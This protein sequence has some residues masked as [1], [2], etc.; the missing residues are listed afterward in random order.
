MPPRLKTPAK[1]PALRISLIYLAFGIIWILFSDRI[2]ATL[3]DRDLII[4]IS[5][6]KGWFYVLITSTILYFLIRRNFDDIVSSRR[7]LSESEERHRTI[8]QTAMDGFWLMDTKGCILEANETLCR[9]LGYSASE[10]EAK[11]ITDLEANETAAD[12]NAHFQ[13]IMVRGEDRF[14][15]RLRRKDGSLVDV[16]VSAKHLPMEDGRIVAFIRDITERKRIEDALTHSEER[17]R[18]LFEMELDAVLMLDWETGRVLEANSSALRMYGYTPE[19]F[20]QLRNADLSAEPAVTEKSIRNE[21]TVVPLRWHRKKDGTVFPVEITG[22]YFDYHGSKVHVAAIRDIT[23]LHRARQEMLKTEKLESL[24]VL[25]GGIAHDFNNILSVILGNISLS[26]IQVHDPDKVAQ[27]LEDAENATVRAKDLTQQLLT[28]SRGGDPVK[29]VVNVGRLLR[30]AAGFAIHGSVVTCEFYLADDLWTVEADEGQLSQVIHNLVINAIQAMPKGGT[31]S[32]AA[33]NAESRS[34]GHKFVKISVADTGTGIPDDLLPKIFDPY[35]TTKQQG[36]GLGLAS[37]FSIIRKHDGKIRVESTLGKGTT[38]HIS[39]PAAE[40]ADTAD[41]AASPEVNRGKGRV[42]VMDDEEMV[43]E[44]TKSMLEECGYLVECAKNGSEAV[45][46][47]V[48]RLREGTPFAVV[49]MDLTIPGEV[50]GREAITSLL[51]IDPK[52]KAIVSSGYATD[53]V[54]AN[55]REYGFS[56]VLSKPYRVEEMSEVLQEVLKD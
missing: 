17:Y 38:F 36:S 21:E 42:L 18:K 44:I 2:V 5:I 54:M 25:A 7:Q 23:E 33:R 49:I 8:L 29:K 13:K 37:C 3:G 48:R 31:I 14:V 1:N 32:V 30:E 55:Y 27:R 35:F 34:E 6:L 45:E 16:E 40:Q 15:S 10:L 41:P 9:I 4:T 50:G 22:S 47:Y 19:E 52:A 46:L 24:G 11:C 12:V 28:F 20:M 51:Q 26:R 53:P 39:L 56:G 43:R